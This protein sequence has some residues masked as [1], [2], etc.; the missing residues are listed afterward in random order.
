M[1]DNPIEGG[2]ETPPL[3]AALEAIEAAGLTAQDIAAAADAAGAPTNPLETRIA[4]LEIQ[5]A[6]LVTRLAA[7]FGG[8]L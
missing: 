5:L 1:S 4:A 8:K 6:D 7:H 2:H 3:D